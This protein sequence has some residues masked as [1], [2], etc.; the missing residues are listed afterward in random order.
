MYINWKMEY[1]ESRWHSIS[2]NGTEFY[3]RF[4]FVIR[5][6]SSELWF[7]STVKQAPSIIV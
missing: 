3:L 4:S 1:G 2:T 6:F 7:E 5:S